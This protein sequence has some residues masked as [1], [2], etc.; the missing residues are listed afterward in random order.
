MLTIL[1][2][3]TYFKGE[4]YLRECRRLGC[5]V[6]LLTAESLAGAEWPRESIDELHTIPRGASDADIRR[7]VDQIAL[8]R[9]IDRIAAL[10]DFDVEMGAMLR[11]HL[12]LPG[13]GRTVASGYRDK[14]AMRVKA[15][16]MG[17]RV[18]EFSPVF[19][20]WELHEFT[21][22]VPGPWVLK[23]RSSAAA[24][25]IKKVANRD[26]LWR[27]LE[28]AGDER[29][30][31]VLEQ[32]VKGEVYH[33]DSI[34]W[35]GRIVFAVAFKYGRPP[36]EVSHDGGIFVTRRLPDDSTEGK[37]L[38]EANER[39][40]QGL[41]M[42]RGVSH[43]EFIRADDGGFVFLETSARVGGAF[44]VDTIEA[45]TGVNL[46]REWAR[47]DAT[48]EGTEYAIPV[49][50]R[51][52]A[53]IVLT[54][55]RQEW[56]DMSGYADPEVVT[57]IRKPHH[58]GV[59]VGAADPQRIEALIGDYTQRFYRDFFATAPPPERPVE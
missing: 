16:A 39:L 45:A 48:P 31:G 41:G 19:N 26:E 35:N 15:R 52:Y 14:L 55:A 51:D 59:I 5:T 6:L 8:K 46:W 4:A 40:Q 56:P 1:C 17:L 30:N 28:A 22:R 58:A 49:P 10:D 47:I 44:I 13:I 18:P 38:L 57:T 24:I 11:E 50:R 42:Q 9:R 2:I 32:F 12:Q 29:S 25:G 27:A 23:P 53:G 34:V 3:A 36:M 20:D 54:L 33:V 21:G 37:G 7:R 43:T